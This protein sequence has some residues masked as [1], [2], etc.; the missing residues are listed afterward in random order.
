MGLGRGL[1][2]ARPDRAFDPVGREINLTAY[3]TASEE[4]GLGT[5]DVAGEL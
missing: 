5:Q 2:F 1:R 3:A 4:A